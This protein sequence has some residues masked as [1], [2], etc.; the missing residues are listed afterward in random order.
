MKHTQRSVLIIVSLIFTA[1]LAGGVYFAAQPTPATLQTSALEKVQ[2]QPQVEITQ[3]LK[4]DNIPPISRPS[5]STSAP[6]GDYSTQPPQHHH[7]HPHSHDHTV[8]IPLEIQAYIEKQR[9]PQSE[10]QPERNPQG[11]LSLNPKGQ[12]ETVSIAVLGEDGDV[13]IT[14]RQIHPL[15]EP[16]QP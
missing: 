16:Q 15:A 4:I 14:E 9:I 6:S 5:L 12:F 1:S 2:P 10:L 7:D 13:R 8:K 3:S 11:N